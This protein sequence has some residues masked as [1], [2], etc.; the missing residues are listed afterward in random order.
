MLSPAPAGV[1]RRGWPKPSWP[2]TAAMAW[3]LFHRRGG[4]HRRV[5]RRRHNPAVLRLHPARP[6]MA[7]ASPLSARH[8]HAGRGSRIVQFDANGDSCL[9]P[10]SALGGCLRYDRGVTGSDMKTTAHTSAAEFVPWPLFL[11]KRLGVALESASGW[12]IARL[13]RLSPA[14][15]L[16]DLDPLA[17]LL[18]GAAD[19]AVHARR[20]SHLRWSGA[21][22]LGHGS[23]AARRQAG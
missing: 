12:P 15:S 6:Y 5:P 3:G 16:G 17:R 7:V 11:S 23:P 22:V 14:P 21:I 19:C 9:W 1:A 13:K 8:V 10:T 20:H 2:P 18:G 4:D